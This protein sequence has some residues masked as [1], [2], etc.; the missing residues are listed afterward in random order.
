MPWHQ[1]IGRHVQQESPERL[2]AGDVGERLTAQAA[3][4]AALV[5]LGLVV[6]ETVMASQA[7]ALDAQQLSHQPF[8]LVARIADGPGKTL[9]R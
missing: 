9:R 6:R 1:N 3:L 7:A 5:L 4:Q 8:G 2:R